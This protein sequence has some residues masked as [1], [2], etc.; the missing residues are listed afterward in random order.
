M[1]SCG[2]PLSD[3]AFDEVMRRCIFDC[4]KWDLQTD[5]VPTL[6]RFPLVVPDREW[7]TLAAAAEALAAEALAAEAE[8]LANPQLLATL[9]LPRSLARAL[10]RSRVA[11]PTPRY[12]RFD[13]HP[14][15]E[16]YRITEGNLD[17]AGGLI[18]SSGVTAI[19]GERYASLRAAGDPA[20]RL[21]DSICA[22]LGPRRRVGLMHLTMYTEDRQ[23]ALY[24]ARR[25]AAAGLE[26]RPFDPAQLRCRQE[27]VCA[28]LGDDVAA[29]DLV[30]RFF[31]AEWLPRLPR[32]TRWPLLLDPRRVHLLN[33][34]SAVLTQSKRFPL[35]WDQL[36]TPLPTWRAFLPETRSPTNVDWE[37]ADWVFKPALGHEGDRVIVSGVSDDADQRR[38]VA[39]VRRDPTGYVAQRRF[40]ATPIA[41]PD[42]LGYPAI[43]VFV[44]DGRAVGAYARLA[45]RPLINDRS[46]DLV[47][48][49]QGDE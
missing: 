46:R 49:L 24:L 11:A 23:V 28:R 7:R 16:G 37:D 47:V 19:F 12:L 36:A 17:V 14:T 18:E 40:V 22:M 30:F 3:G 42:G 6:C 48:L 41:T 2:A 5:G 8:I 34:I 43:G 27:E 33:P 31:P 21:V 38:F 4:C 32:A 20:A 26:P 39:A 25:F 13:F 10:A 15:S 44:V 1:L 45:N 9:G 35:L 29:L